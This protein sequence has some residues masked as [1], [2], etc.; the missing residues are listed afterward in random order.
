MK[1]I[2][3]PRKPLQRVNITKYLP[4]IERVAKV[5]YRRIPSHMVD[6]EE[7]VSIGAIAIQA[8]LKN[9][10]P[11]QA[12]KLNTSYLATAT[13]WAIRNELRTR[14]KWYTLKHAQKPT[15]AED[16]DAPAAANAEGAAAEGAEVEHSPEQVRE[17]VYETILSIEGIS[18]GM[19]GDSPYEFIKDGSATPAEQLEIVELG[20]AIKKAIESLPPKERTIVEYRFYRNMQVKD[21]ATI[22]GLSSSRITRIVQASLNTVRQYLKDQEHIDGL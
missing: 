4:L 18:E 5:E 16:T 12:A 22:V 15:E 11:E 20:R 13:R 19:D 7:L 21:I 14:Y 3:P 6:Y 1:P 17:A 10:T 9:K 2:P 8:L